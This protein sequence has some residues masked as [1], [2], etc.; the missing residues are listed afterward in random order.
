MVKAVH[1]VHVDSWLP[2]ELEPLAELAMN[3]RWSWDAGLRDLFQAAAPDLWGQVGRNP[4]ALLRRLPLNRLLALAEDEEFV[5][6]LREAH[7]EVMG[8]LAGP[9][10]RSGSNPHVAFFSPEFALTRAMQTYS[11]GLGVLAGDYLKAASDSQLPMVGVGLLYWRGYFRQSLD[12]AGWQQ[13]H[14]PDLDPVELPLELVRTAAGEPATVEVPLAG[15]SVVC[16]LWRANV[17]RVLLLL[18]DTDDPANTGD[19]R[20]VTDTLYGGDAEKRLR[21]EIVLGVGGVR[22][23]ELAVGLGVLDS[24]PSVFHSNEGHAGFLGL[25]RVRRLI[26]EDGLT[27]DEA[28]ESGRSS[29]LFTTHTPVPAGI[30]VFPRHLM[31]RYFQDF[32]A[33]CG[34]SMD[35]LMAVG[36]E[37][38]EPPGTAFNMAMLGLRLSAAANGVSRLHG[39][40]ARRMFSPLWPSVDV[41][42]VPIGSVT[43]GVHPSTWVGPDMAAV[44]ERGLPS[45]WASNPEAWAG[46]EELSDGLLWQARRR[47]R[48]RLVRE[49][50]ERLRT[51]HERRGGAR[52]LAGADEV[53]DPEALTIGFARRFA[54]YKRSTLLLHQP[55]RLRALLTSR[56]QPVQL[57]FA[58]KAHPR[59]ELGKDL[60]RQLARVSEDSALRPRMVFVEDYDV[61]LAA[62]LVQGVDL[63]LNTPRRPHEACG[64]SGQ[65]AVLNGALHCSTLDGWW[66]EMADGQNGFCIGTATE[67]SDSGEQDAADA[68]ELYLL[69]ERTVVPMFYDRTTQGVPSRWLGRV[70]HSLA[71]LAPQVLAN[72]MVTEYAADHYRPLA[73]RAARLTADDHARARRLAA[74]RKGV[75]DRW[76]GVELEEVTLKGGPARVGDSREV[77]VRVRLGG[78]SPQDVRVELLHGP[79]DGDGQLER[80]AQTVPLDLFDADDGECRYTGTFTCGVPGEYGI[81]ARVVA[82]HSDLVHWTD[83]GL[84][85]WPRDEQG[86]R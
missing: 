34:I 66:A 53:L 1:K 73:D 44:F 30:D 68:E 27:F 7:G 9:D 18:L 70:R 78:L 49:V 17:G 25:E 31:E 37:P 63:W 39:R 15:R 67:H 45:D 58:G 4:V 14:Y 19:D 76:A 28:V 43:N 65:K 3:L 74:W 6:H 24:S 59:D 22:A 42:E 48:H 79:V 75:A 55:E 57:V 16:R 40:V 46:A 12:A 13:E 56:E 71:T 61:D 26:L 21:Q 11:G 20:T 80:P 85:A 41:D 84:V 54:E 83:A 52:G 60:I 62:A 64:T 82:D 86:Q 5:G 35:R 2:P 33:E 47:A 10:V 8:E 50:R 51:Q 38:G 72:R 77:E 29:V 32:A 69:L 81:S 23:L 36:Q